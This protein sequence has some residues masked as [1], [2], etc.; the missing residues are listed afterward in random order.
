MVLFLSAKFMSA[1][2]KTLIFFSWFGFFFLERKKN[3]V[4]FAFCF[5][6]LNFFLSVFYNTSAIIIIKIITYSVALTT[7]SGQLQKERHFRFFIA[8]NHESVQTFSSV[9]FV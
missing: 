2:L 5:G 1:H 8:F 9:E 7:H 4:S 6:G 3:N